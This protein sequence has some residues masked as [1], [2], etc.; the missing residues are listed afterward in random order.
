M[1]LIPN[2]E[3][4]ARVRARAKALGSDGCTAVSEWNEICCLH[5]DIMRRTGHDVDGNP[6]KTHE[7]QNV[8]FWECNRIR[9]Q[10]RLSYYDPRSWLRFA[11]VQIGSWWSQRPKIAAPF[12]RGRAKE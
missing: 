4:E 1:V 9:A 2:A 12:D 6:V 5:H 7:E 11:G 10:S 3:W 8:L